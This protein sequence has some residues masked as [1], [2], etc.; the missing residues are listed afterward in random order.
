MLAYYRYHLYFR[1]QQYDLLF[2]GVR[3]ST[4]FHPHLTASDR[5]DVV[6]R[7]FEQNIQALIAFLKEE[8]LYT[9][10]FQKRG[11]PHCH[12]LLWVNSASRIRIAEDVDRFILAEL[13]DP[14]IDP[15]GYNVVL[16]L[17]MHGPCGAVNLKAA[18]MKGDKYSKKFPKNSIRR[19]SLMKWSCALSE[20]RH[21][22]IYYK[23]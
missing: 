12:T 23:K 14:R 18:C 16:E 4:V 17:M 7:V 5:A 6:C 19:P 20:K 9:V 3:K 11:L 2:R 13:P 8:L 10:E 15:K 1:L 21:K 22:Y